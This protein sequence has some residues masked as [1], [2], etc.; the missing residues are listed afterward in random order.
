LL[1]SLT[2]ASYS[3]K[4]T[5]SIAGFATTTRAV[6]RKHTVKRGL[7]QY[8]LKPDDPTYIAVEEDG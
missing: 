5:A 6:K 7:T 4:L 3:K 1:V 8:T 2:A